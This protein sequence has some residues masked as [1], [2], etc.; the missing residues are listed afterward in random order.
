[1]FEKCTLCRKHRKIT[2][3]VCKSTFL[4]QE[5][6]NLDCD[7]IEKHIFLPAVERQQIC[8]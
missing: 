7:K 1:M 6:Y 3:S 4:I 8:T 2:F 5:K